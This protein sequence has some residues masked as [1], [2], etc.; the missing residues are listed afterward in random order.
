MPKPKPLTDTARAMPA[1]GGW[2]CGEDRPMIPDPMIPDPMMRAL[3]SGM[4][5]MRDAGLNQEMASLVRRMNQLL[6]RDDDAP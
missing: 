5:D 4:A 2:L 1:A 6:R 3:P